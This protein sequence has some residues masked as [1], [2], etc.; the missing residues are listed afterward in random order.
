MQ[1]DLRFPRF[2][3]I[4]AFHGARV[5]GLRSLADAR[6][7]GV[8]LLGQ[9]VRTRTRTCVKALVQG[10]ALLV[11]FP[12]ALTTGF[13]RFGPMFRFFSHCF[14]LVPG[15]PGDYLRVAYY[16][17]TLEHCSVYSR[18]SFG[19]FFAQSCASVGR[20]VYVGAY[21]VLG[22]CNIGDRTQIASHVQ[23][24]AGQHQHARAADGQ[25]LGADEKAFTTISIGEDCWVGAS[26]ILMAD[27]GPR[28][29]IGA[30]AIVT[31]AIPADVIAI[32]NP[33]RVLKTRAPEGQVASAIERKEEMVC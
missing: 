7:G 22:A 12:L 19:S 9:R 30:G 20:G 15:L 2:G 14:A 33:A 21:C 4:G 29:T 6:I 8:L 31:R 5:L 1:E 32:G 13:G 23:T 24:V 3:G 28:S 16:V 17:L 27:V 25:I 26:A 10:T 11:A 18:I